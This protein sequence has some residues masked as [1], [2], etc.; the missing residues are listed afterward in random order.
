MTSMLII[1]EGTVHYWHSPARQ[2]EWET[3][4]ASPYMS[5]YP[6]FNIQVIIF[7]QM[8]E[9]GIRLVIF[10]GRDTESKKSPRPLNF[11][12][13]KKATEMNYIEF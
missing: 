12:K 3:E 2:C 7:C 11:F 4:R 9:W 8:G 5:T 6:V 13:M 1:S 10:T